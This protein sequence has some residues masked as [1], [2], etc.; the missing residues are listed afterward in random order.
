MKYRQL[1]LIV[2]VL[3]NW[4]VQVIFIIA[5]LS[6]LKWWVNSLLSLSI[7]LLQTLI[8]TCSTFINFIPW[9]LWVCS[10]FCAHSLSVRLNMFWRVFAGSDSSWYCISGRQT[11]SSSCTNCSTLSYFF[12]CSYSKISHKLVF[13]S[14]F[15]I[16]SYNMSCWVMVCWLLIIFYVS[17]FLS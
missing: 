6:V 4:V 11:L 1:M 16:N 10:I 14:F 13:Q 17:F 7:L 2:K 3:F 12:T 8:K 9:A 15:S 5:P